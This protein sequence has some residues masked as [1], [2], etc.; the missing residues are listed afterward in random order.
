MRAVPAAIAVLLLAAAGCSSDPETVLQSDLPQV[1]GMAPRDTIGLRQE[2]GRVTGGQFAY[3]GAIPALGARAQETM[4]RF[5]SLGWQLSAETVTG[6]TAVLV[7]RK[8]S[9]TARV[10]IIRNA[11]QPRMSTAVITVETAA[12]PGPAPATPAPATPAPATPAPAAPTPAAP[13]PA[14]APAQAPVSG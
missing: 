13:A 2:G 12:A 10:E 4:A 3:T 5:G 1:P 7:Y 6:S 9:R 11:L 14:A 8:D